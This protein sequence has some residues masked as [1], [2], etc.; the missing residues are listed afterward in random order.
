MGSL[1]NFCKSTQ[2]LAP[3]C[4]KEQGCLLLLCI[5]V[6][7]RLL[8]LHFSI[9]ICIYTLPSP[10]W[11][12]LSGLYQVSASFKW[13][14]SGINLLLVHQHLKESFQMLDLAEIN[15]PVSRK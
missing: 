8:F 10:Q 6:T 11:M 4:L 7:C 2:R 5:E 15:A 9:Q 14:R 12:L 3:G 1:N 13:S